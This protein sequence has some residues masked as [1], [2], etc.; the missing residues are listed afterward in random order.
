MFFFNGKEF[1]EAKTYTN[2]KIGKAIE[3]A[4]V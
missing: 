3:N 2:I 4:W 1:L